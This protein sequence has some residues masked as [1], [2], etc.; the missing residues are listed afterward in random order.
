MTGLRSEAWESDAVRENLIRL[1]G[2]GLPF[3]RI[4]FPQYSG[5]G[6]EDREEE[7]EG[8]EGGGRRRGRERR[9]EGELLTQKAVEAN[10]LYDL[11]SG[12]LLLAALTASSPP[13]PS[14]IK[15]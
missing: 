3:R 5:S 4:Y 8:G 13:T 15:P 11:Q 10:S 9:G 2:R 14:L 12:Y 1:D 6:R 7:G